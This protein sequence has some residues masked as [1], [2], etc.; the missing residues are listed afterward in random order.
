MAPNSHS[1]SELRPLLLQGMTERGAASAPR[2]VAMIAGER[3]FTYEELHDLVLRCVPS[4]SDR[5]T[6]SGIWASTALIMS[7]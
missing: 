5:A 7:C 3:R 6:G 4:V 2:Q 1:S